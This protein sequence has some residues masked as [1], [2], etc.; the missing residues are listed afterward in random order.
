M[1]KY[2]NKQLTRMQRLYRKHYS[3]I[4]WYCAIEGERI[5][6]R[7]PRWRLLRKAR[8]RNARVYKQRRISKKN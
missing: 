2:R 6:K 1:K 3:I 7:K 4:Q 8:K 5:E